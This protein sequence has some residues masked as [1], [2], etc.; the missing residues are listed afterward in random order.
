MHD[1]VDV[2]LPPVTVPGVSVHVRFVEFELV[3]RVTVPAN[4]LTGATVTVEVPAKPAISVTVV[5][6]AVTA[7][8]WTVNATIAE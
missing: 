8:S 4:A 6:L 3:E 2:P 5:G 1:N 7:K